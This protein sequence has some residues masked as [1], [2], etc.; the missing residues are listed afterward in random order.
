MYNITTSLITQEEMTLIEKAYRNYYD[1]RNTIEVQERQGRFTPT[2]AM[3]TQ[4]DIATEFKDQLFD[5]IVVV[6]N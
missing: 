5:I 3:K 4:M 1:K 6:K 2:Q